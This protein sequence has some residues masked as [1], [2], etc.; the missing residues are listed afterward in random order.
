M[1]FLQTL[2]VTSITYQYF[3]LYVFYTQNESFESFFKYT[4]LS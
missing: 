2:Y 1:Y 3:D 4:Q